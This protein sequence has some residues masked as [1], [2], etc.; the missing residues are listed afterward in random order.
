MNHEQACETI[1]EIIKAITAET[2]DLAPTSVQW[3]AQLHSAA[4]K[5]LPQPPPR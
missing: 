3:A 1:I 2:A 4:L 5:N